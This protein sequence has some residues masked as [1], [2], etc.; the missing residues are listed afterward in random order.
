MLSPCLK[1]DQAVEDAPA[2][3]RRIRTKADIIG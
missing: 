2:E 1:H 3:L